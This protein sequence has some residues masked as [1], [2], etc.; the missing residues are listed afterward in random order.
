MQVKCSKNSYWDAK[1]KIFNYIKDNVKKFKI[2]IF[3]T[4]SIKTDKTTGNFMDRLIEQAEKLS[5][6]GKRTKVK[7]ELT[8]K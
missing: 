4:M 7:E 3:N 8:T 6:M 5:D 2:T 1:E